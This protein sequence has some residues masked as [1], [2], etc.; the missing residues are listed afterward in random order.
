MDLSLSEEQVALRDMVGSILATH[1]APENL[2]EV[3]GTDERY[4]VSAE[5]A[6]REAGLIELGAGEDSDTNLVELGILLSELG[7][8]AYTGPFHASVTAGLTAQRLLGDAG[9]AVVSRVEGGGIAAVCE[10][11]A[12]SFDGSAAS[13]NASGI[14]WAD[15]A[16]L[17]VVSAPVADGIGLWVVAP[18]AEGVQIVP[19]RGMDG[20]RS[21]SVTLSGAPIGAPAA[22]I[23]AKQWRAHSHL[24]RVLRAADLVGVMRRVLEMTV[25]HVKQREQFG[26]FIGQFQAVQH[27]LANLSLDLE[28]STNMVNHALWRESAGFE[29]ER[30]AAESAWFVSDAAVRATQVGNQLHGG[31]GFMKEYHLHHFHNRSAVQRGRMGSEQVRLA[32]LGDVV[33]E[34]AELDFTEEFMDWPVQK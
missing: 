16:D 33:I 21:G 22:V 5:Q 32:E 4:S 28:A 18:D 17:L 19:Q 2:N 31:I 26:K 34:A 20:S 10:F 13:G 12:L 3:L 8:V 9:A 1:A 23:T 25:T 30:A 14:E 7:Y 6:L 29:S 15:G 24:L 27:H 11:T